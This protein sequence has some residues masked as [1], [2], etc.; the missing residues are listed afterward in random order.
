MKKTIKIPVLI[1]NNFLFIP[2]D[3]TKT[4]NRIEIIDPYNNTLY[5]FKAKL[6]I[7]KA[8]YYT[9]LDVSNHLGRELILKIYNT[10]LDQ[11]I[12][13]CLI[14]KPFNIYNY[15]EKHRP[16]YHFSSPFGWINDPN[17]LYY[18]NGFYHLYYQYNPYGIKWG[19]ISWGHATSQDLIHWINHP[20]AILQNHLGDVFSGS[21]IIDNNNDAGFGKKTICAFYTS[22]SDKQ[23]QSLAYS[24][25]DGKTFKNYMNNPILTDEENKDFRDPKL[26]WH[27]QTNKWIMAL[28]TGQT[29]TFYSSTNLK[30]WSKLSIFGNGIGC[31]KGVWECPDLFEISNGTITKWV[32]FVSINPGGP[33][34][35]NATQYFIGEFDGTTFTPDDT[36]YPLWLDYGRDNYAGVTW[37]NNPNK[38]PRYIGWMSNWDYANEIPTKNFTNAM[39]LPRTIELAKNGNSYCLRTQPIKELKNLR[40]EKYLIESKLLQKSILVPYFFDDNLGAYEILLDFV[41]IDQSTSNVNLTLSNSVDENLLFSFDIK[42][43]KLT[44]DRSKSG[45]VNF[46]ENFA[47]DKIVAPFPSQIKHQLKLFIDKASSELFINKGKIAVTNLIFPTEPYSSINLEVEN[48][49]IDITKFT[50]YKLQ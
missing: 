36:E 22:S 11:S 16:L 3:E 47:K 35:G 9:P 39:T 49:S 15:C 30:A 33:N 44:I 41:I 38:K 5:S 23:V 45:Q 29:I 13:E 40:A 12:S 31:H 7:E 20:P 18:K 26:F 28:A 4:E 37:H 2:I 10:T 46:S 6:S 43:E 17:G 8:Q 34:G 42:N 21:I 50:I 27:K 1:T 48:G 14:L 19:N 24:T 25:D 32:L